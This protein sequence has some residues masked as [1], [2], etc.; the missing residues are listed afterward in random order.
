M[1]F[2]ADRSSHTRHHFNTSYHISMKYTI[3]HSLPLLSILILTRHCFPGCQGRG[4][5]ARKF[6]SFC[7]YCPFILYIEYH[8]VHS[9]STFLFLSLIEG[10]KSGKFFL[11]LQPWYLLFQLQCCVALFSSCSPLIVCICLTFLHCDFSNVFSNCLREK[12]HSNIGCI[13]LTCLHCA[14]SNVCLA[15]LR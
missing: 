10:Q 3:S 7:S 1:G 5:W 2:L 8:I 15:F 9:P 4:C 13:C 12:R 11:R 6:L 14:F